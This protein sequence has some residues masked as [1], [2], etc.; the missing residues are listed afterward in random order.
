M[1]NDTLFRDNS[2]RH[3]ATGGYLTTK[4]VIG[5]LK[6]RVQTLATIQCNSGVCVCSR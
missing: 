5:P 2:S 6:V 4:V 1:L 3:W